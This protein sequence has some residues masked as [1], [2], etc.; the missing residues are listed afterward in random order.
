M[1]H[2]WSQY[3]IQKTIFLKVEKTYLKCNFGIYKPI[4]ETHIYIIILNKHF[5]LIATSFFIKNGTQHV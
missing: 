5:D 3:Q 4:Y 2:I 1:G